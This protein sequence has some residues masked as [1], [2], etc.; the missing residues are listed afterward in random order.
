MN[1]LFYLFR[2]PGWGGIETVT[3]VIGSRLIEK[4]H[5]VFI[6]SHEAQDRASG[7]TGDNHCFQMPDKKRCVSVA[8][9][10]FAESL[11][12]NQHIDVV[13][14]QDCYAP[15]EKIAFRMKEAGARLMV[16]EHNTPLHLQKALGQIPKRTPLHT[17][18]RKWSHPKKIKGSIRRHL[19]L[20]KTADRYVVLAKGYIA[21]L[22]DLCGW[23]ATEPY[24]DKLCY[25]NNPLPDVRQT[26][27]P[28]HTDNTL[29]FVGQ[30][31]HQKR[32]HLMLEAWGQLSKRF[33][34]WKLQIVGDGILRD[35]ME[36]ITRTRS[37]KRVEFC[38]YRDPEAY[39]LGAKLFW[40]TSAFEGWP[41]TLLESMIAA[42]VPIVTDSFAAARDIID[43]KRDGRLIPDGDLQSFIDASSLLMEDETLRVTMAGNA[44]QK[45]K[46]FSADHIVEKWIALIQEDDKSNRLD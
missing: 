17:L 44:V 21:E 18:Y 37:L 19:A 4:G 24:A 8:N 12:R 26:G 11:V 1:I 9:L 2:F 22:R 28:H 38:G 15:T 46:Q 42:C 13:I 27:D 45:A 30:I 35:R 41:M 43:D 5:Q 40:M 20:L 10:S 14:Y 36:E 3:E 33:P 31:N 29:L 34:D 25:I 32:I 6:L 16:F 7:L 39:Y 23:E